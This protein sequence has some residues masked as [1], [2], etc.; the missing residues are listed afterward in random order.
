MSEISLITSVKDD[1]SLIKSVKINWLNSEKYF[2][3]V[4]Q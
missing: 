2:S 3:L 1:F 4:K